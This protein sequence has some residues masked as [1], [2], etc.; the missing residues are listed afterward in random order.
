MGYPSSQPRYTAVPQP[1]NPRLSEGWALTEAARRIAEAKD[2][3]GAKDDFLAAVRLNWRLWTIFQA[4]LTMD[5]CPLPADLRAN[6]LAL[7]NFIDKRTISIIADPDPQKADVLISINRQ[8][9]AGLLEPVPE[10][11]AEQ[12]EAAPAKLDMSN[13]SV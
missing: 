1:G 4:E 6:L 8:I 12:A 2:R 13:F 9:A 11:A 5:Y 3:P 7:S 10:G